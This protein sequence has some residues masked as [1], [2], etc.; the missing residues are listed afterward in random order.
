MQLKI[1]ISY[2]KTKQNKTK[3]PANKPNN[4]KDTMMN[5]LGFCKTQFFLAATS[6]RRV[7]TPKDRGAQRLRVFFWAIFQ[8]GGRQK[9]K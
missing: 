8:G 6:E 4:T 5:L 9:T 3:T 1:K 2:K 7:K